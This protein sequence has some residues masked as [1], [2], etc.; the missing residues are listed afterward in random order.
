MSI[1]PDTQ[2]VEVQRI[3]VQN[4]PRKKVSETPISTNK[5]GITACTCDPSCKEGKVGGSQFEPSL[6][7][8]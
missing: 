5:L 4:H 8:K 2:E 6:K 7:Q 3:V 1:S